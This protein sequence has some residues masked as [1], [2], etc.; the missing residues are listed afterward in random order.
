[1]EFQKLFVIFQGAGD[2]GVKGKRWMRAKTGPSDWNVELQGWLVEETPRSIR[3]LDDSGI[4]HSIRK[5][6]PGEQRPK[7]KGKDISLEEYFAK[8]HDAVW[9]LQPSDFSEVCRQ[10]LAKGLPNVDRKEKGFRV[11]DG[12][13]SE[14]S[15]HAVK[16]CRYACWAEQ[17][18][19]KD[20]AR[21]LYAQAVKV[22]A[23]YTARFAPTDE[24]QTLHEF[25]ANKLASW[26]RV[27]AISGGHGGTSRQEILESWEVV[28]KIPYHKFHEEAQEMIRAY[29]SLLAEDRGWTEPKPEALA[30]MTSEQKAAYWLYHLR[31]ADAG[32]NSDPGSCH[33]L[34]DWSYAMVLGEARDKRPK[35]PIELQKLGTAALP[36]LISHLDD[37]R[38]TRCEGHWRSYSPES[39]YLLRYGDCCQQI[40]E[41]ITGF[42]IHERGGAA[43]DYPMK[44]GKGKEVRARA[45]QWWQD[46]QRKGEKQ[47][48]IE[49]TEKGKRDSPEQ[50]RRLIA[51]YPDVSLEPIRKGTRKMNDSWDRTWMVKA[52][53]QLKSDGAI[54]FFREE[55]TGPFLSSR[56][57][58][59]KGLLLH[60]DREG[61]RGLVREW[62][63]LKWENYDSFQDEW[64]IDELIECLVASGEVEAIHTLAA[65]FHNKPVHVRSEII[66]YLSQL[67]NKDM[68]GQALSAVFRDAID[69][70]LAAALTDMDTVASLR[71]GAD[72]KQVENPA[73]GD[74]AAEAMTNQWN[75]PKLFDIYGSLQARERQRL[76]VK[77]AWLTKRGRQPL[78]VALHRKTTPAPDAA[79]APLLQAV[80][81]ANT[82]DAR[83]EALKK[84]ESIGL[85]ALPAL[86]KQLGKLTIAH[87]A[88][89][90]LQTA[91][92]RIG[93]ILAEVRY[94]QDSAKPT[95][96]MADRVQAYLNRP[97]RHEDFMD[98][99]HSVLRDPPQGTRGIKLILEREG[100]DNGALLIVSLVADKKPAP[101]LAPQ[102]DFRRRIVIGS[103]RVD[104]GDSVLAGIGR[105][106]GLSEL[107]LG[108]FTDKLKAAFLAAP[109]EYLLVELLC[110]ERR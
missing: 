108:D 87:R 71:G 10:F 95:K 72:G 16:A 7:G 23:L 53:H 105:K 100:T 4:I 3:L 19:E 83:Q 5:P 2:L 17:M 110:A 54:A 75:Q 84:L 88:H 36:L 91:A 63:N 42:T 90:E 68:R 104:S 28:A 29:K 103:K 37:P 73:I 24:S 6:Q 57:A 27:G 49:G 34:S 8:R 98:L 102:L 45:Q 48:L 55:A 76:E 30:R 101:N 99:L 15:D 81:D 44:D 40:F 12:G 51:K 92:R 107:E 85:P 79:T 82:P 74:L 43:S 13:R 39:F 70:L 93:F 94:A 50:A 35:P 22:H 106:V 60:G 9:D 97:I 64:H 21:K 47:I 69:D 33:V 20:L 1:L 32:Q 59:D 58:A 18:T 56:V 66:H 41:G 86:R 62:N 77:N 67:E 96:E 109:N 65:E 38:P 80:L 61:L 78:P 26:Y 25:I 46:Y 31:D 89:A 11:M 14:L 52:V